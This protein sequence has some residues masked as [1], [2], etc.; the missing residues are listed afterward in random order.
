MLGTGGLPI[1]YSPL[2]NYSSDARRP[3]KGSLNSATFVLAPLRTPLVAVASRAVTAIKPVRGDWS[4]WQA[5]L[6]LP[7][8]RSA[9][10]RPQSSAYVQS[11]RQDHLRVVAKSRRYPQIGRAH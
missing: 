6:S 4:L 2:P 11:G 9:G 7:S 8:S 3:L 1:C 5:E 10:P